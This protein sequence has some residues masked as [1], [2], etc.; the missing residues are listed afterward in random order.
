MTP[1]QNW[2]FRL[3]M[4]RLVFR[5]AA[6]CTL[7]SRFSLFAIAALICLLHATTLLAAPITVSRIS[8]NSGPTSGGTTVT[9]AGRNFGAGAMVTFGGVAATNVTVVNST[10]ITA[11]TPA[12]SVGAVTVTVTVSGQSGKLSSG[13]TYTIIPT[14]SSIS[15]NSGPK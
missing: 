8:P 12:G 2:P 9:I 7:A 3:S 13:F 4:K 14:V 6:E 5:D 10:T 15:P 1:Q 11:T